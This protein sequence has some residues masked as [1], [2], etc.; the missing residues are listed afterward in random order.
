MQL[1]FTSD[2]GRLGL[3][4]LGAGGHAWLHPAHPCGLYGVAIDG[5]YWN[6]TNMVFC[7]ALNEP[8][9]EGIEHTIFT[10]KAPGFTVEHHLKVY[11]DTALLECWPI[12]RN[13]GAAALFVERVDSIAI[14]L[15]HMPPRQAELLYYTGLWGSEFEP[16]RAPMPASITLETRS[17]RA[18]KGCHPWFALTDLSGPVLSGAVAWSGNWAIRFEWLASGGLALSGGLNDW[19]FSKMLAPGETMEAAPFILVMGSDLNA[20]SQQY[21]QIGRRYWYPHNQLSDRLPV[22]WN[23]WWPYED[24]EINETVFAENIRKA[25]AMGFEVCTLDAG[26]FG[27]SNTGTFWEHY[28]GDWALVNAQRFPSGIR[29]LADLAH[30]H[31]MA[32]GIW[33]EIEAL[34]PKAGLAHEFPEYIARR[35]GEPLG[36]VCFG[37]PAVREWAYQTLCRLVNDFGANWIKLDFNLDPGAGCN[38]TDHGHQAGDGLYEHYRGYYRTLD[39]FRHDFPEV[40]LENCSSGGLRIDLGMLRRTHL[41]YLSDPDW[42]DHDLQIFWGA[43][44]MLAPDRLLHWTYSHWRNLNPPPYQKFDPHDPALTQKKWDYYSRISMLG[45]YG[46]SQKLP[47][48]PAWLEQRIVYHNHIYKEHIRR[49]IK[50]ARLYRLTNQPLRSGNGDRWAAFQYSLPD[51]SEHLLFV[52]RLPGAAAQLRI[53]LQNLDAGR[54]YRITGF[55]DRSEQQMRGHDLMET[56]LL[57]STLDEEEAALLWLS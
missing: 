55:E 52:F 21:A 54:L 28:R 36:C 30:T 8:A 20:V 12:I 41:T 11:T 17:G 45:L 31:G 16:H 25:A 37:C 27:P 33:C 42:P 50:A 39:R 32:F 51:N 26:W 13:T 38:R 43:S 5:Q 19:Q 48:L 35:D 3:D 1:R 46:I 49:F 57:F 22:E 14:V 23:H 15:P 2:E 7:G 44:T 29:P 18:S 40:V 9:K 10:F 6:A 34:G 24:A 53:R 4:R 47:E 56:G